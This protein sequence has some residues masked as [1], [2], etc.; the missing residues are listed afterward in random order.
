MPTHEELDRSKSD[1]KAVGTRIFE[2]VILFVLIVTSA[3]LA[4]NFLQGRNERNARE[5]TIERI[6]AIETGLEKYLIDSGGTLPTSKQGLAALLEEP[7]EGPQ[8]RSWNGPYIDGREQLRD[9]WGRKFHY[10]CPGRELD[11]YEEL[12][13]PYSLWSYGSDGREGGEDADAD[14]CSW[15]RTTMMP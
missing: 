15:D 10:I 13:H 7:T 14:I 8:P 2:I 3:L 11:G 4:T 6:S 9:A 12:Y 5:V 1:E